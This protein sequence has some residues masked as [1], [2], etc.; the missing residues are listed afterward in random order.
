MKQSLSNKPCHLS[1]VEAAARFLGVKDA[2]V[3]LF[4][5]LRYLHKTKFDITAQ[6]TSYQNANLKLSPHHTTQIAKQTTY[7]L[8]ECT[9]VETVDLFM[10]LQAQVMLVVEVCLPNDQ[11]S[12]Q[13][14][15]RQSIVAKHLKGLREITTQ[16]KTDMPQ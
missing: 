5:C 13:G 10:Q 8:V 15:A 2:V 9:D 6:I 14:I 12:A 1:P 4:L 3:L 11:C 16:E 7:Q